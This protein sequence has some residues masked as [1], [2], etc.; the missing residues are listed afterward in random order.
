MTEPTPAHQIPVDQLA[1]DLLPA[2]LP[3]SNPVSTWRR[4]GGFVGPAISVGIL[5][6]ALWQ[7]HELDWHK[8]LTIFRATPWIW[9]VLG[10]NYLSGPL[11]DWV[12]FRKLW[13]IPVEGI[14]PLIKKM[15]GNQILLSYVGEVYFYDWAR[16]HVKMEGSPFGAVKDVAILSAMAGYA[17]T[18][19]ML[20]VAWPYF[21]RPAFGFNQRELYGSIAVMLVIGLVITIFRNRV[22]SLPR[23]DLIFVLVVHMIRLLTNTVLTAVLWSMMLPAVALSTWLMLS[24]GRLLVTRLPL[25]PNQ[26][27]AFAG[28]LALLGGPA[29]QTHEMITVIALF[30]TAIHIVVYIAMLLLDLVQ[31][32][33]NA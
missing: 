29:D 7:V 4:L 23:N 19:I 27:I 26:E 14:F 22:L 5:G 32:E 25:I 1:A 20:A 13:K 3:R 9:L 16:R 33:R 15:I 17:M 28:A 24:T 30:I 8:L 6:G 2:A 18:L 12:I 31:R 11:G 10:V 21:N